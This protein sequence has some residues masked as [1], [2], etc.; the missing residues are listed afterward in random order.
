MK[1]NQYCLLSY[2]MLAD[3][4]LQ[5]I[6]AVVYGILWDFCA[7]GTN[8]CKIKIDTIVHIT[9]IS[10]STI[11]RALKTLESIGYISVTHTQQASIYTLLTGI[12]PPKTRK[13]RKNMKK[14][15]TNTKQQV[16][17]EKLLPGQL[18]FFSESDPGRQSDS[19]GS[20][21][22]KMRWGKYRHVEMTA[23]EYHELVTMF[24]E[25]LVKNYIQKIDDYC[26]LYGKSYK[27]YYL[28][29]KKWI[30]E[31]KLKNPKDFEKQK[32]RLTDEKLAGYLSLVNRFKDD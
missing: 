18:D 15:V 13:N 21:E 32:N 11:L 4:R 9:S 23:E 25:R 27:N 12:L 5:V 10:K 20:S 7:D 24:S 3:E 8:Q 16:E 2:D 6:D 17:P 22:V 14:S 19:S 29:I 30:D 1:K 26:E 28:A 31:D